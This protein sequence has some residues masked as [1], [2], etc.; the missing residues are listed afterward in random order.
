MPLTPG[1]KFNDLVAAQ[2]GRFTRGQ[3]HEADFSSFRISRRIDAG[4]WRVV[5]GRLLAISA[6]PDSLES[7]EWEALLSAGPGA[8]FAG[9]SAARRLSI[10]VPDRRPCVLVPPSRRPDVPGAVV[11]RQDLDD[12]DLL[13]RDDCLLTGNALTVVEC[14]LL[15]D[16]PAAMMFLERALQRHWISF[17]E[18]TLRVCLATGRHGAPKLTRVVRALRSGARSDSERRLIRGLQHRGVGGWRC[19]LELHDGNGTIGV[20]DLAFRRVRLAIELDGRAWHVD[21]ERFQHDRTRQNR[22]IAA[23]WTVLR[24]TWEDVAYRLDSVIGEIRAAVE[25]LGR[26]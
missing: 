18:L 8:V 15:L 26:S 3:A 22:L 13:V 17:D 1:E 12:N 2:A 19:N 14:A 25:R 7:R 24:F 21:R 10:E 20:L 6:V 16:E 11:L 4:E 5:R 9:P 23:G